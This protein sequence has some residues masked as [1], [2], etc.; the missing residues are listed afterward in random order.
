MVNPRIVAALMSQEQEYQVL[1]GEAARRAAREHGLD[2][3]VFFSG[4]TAIDQVQQLTSLLLAPV[5]LRPAAILVET[6]SG[7]A[8]ERI[9]RKAAEAGIAWFLINRRAPYIAQLRHEFPRVPICAVSA[10]Q[11]EIGRIQGRQLQ[12]LLPG[13]GTVLYIQ[14]RA[15]TSPARER[16]AGTREVLG[17]AVNLRVYAGEWTLSGG[18]KATEGWLRAQNGGVS[19][20]QAVAAQNDLMAMGAREA[21]LAL[22]PEWSRIPFLGCDGLPQGGLKLVAS[23]QLAATV[24]NPIDG[25]SRAVALFA[26]WRRSGIIPPDELLLA[27]ES[28]PAIQDLTQIGYG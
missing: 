21:F 15:D 6:I 13:G 27:P 8:L 25:G 16:L 18:R 5:D 28:F 17:D 3:D 24:V 26:D 2:L 23:G 4:D 12:T 14:G 20:P 1:L 7:E 10:D 22:R 19:R 11:L 9:A